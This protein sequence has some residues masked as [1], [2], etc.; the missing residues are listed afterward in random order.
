MK[1]HFLLCI[2]EIS[3]AC[4]RAFRGDGD[5]SLDPHSGDFADAARAALRL[6]DAL[7]ALGLAGY[8]KTSGKRGLHVF[9][10]IRVGP[11][12][13][14]VRECAAALAHL[15]AVEYPKELTVEAR[16]SERKG[17]VYIDPARNSFG[18]TVVAP[19]AVRHYPGAPVSA[20]LDWSE[21][22]PAF[23][24]AHVN[25]GTI[26]KRL[27]QPDPWADFFRRR[28]SLERMRRA[29]GKV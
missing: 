12:V 24:P 29:V 25:L 14:Q 11:D 9:V 5:K 8:S 21:V 26:D 27:T 7:D 3:N 28:Q 17:R 20:P 6:K 10:P 19:Y 15:L 1:I 4:K 16:I 2:L 23:D 13:D 22:T 18:Q